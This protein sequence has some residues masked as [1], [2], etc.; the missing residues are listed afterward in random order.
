MGGD[1]ERQKH[2]LVFIRKMSSAG[3]HLYLLFVLVPATLQGY[4]SGNC[5]KRDSLPGPLTTLLL[6]NAGHIEMGSI[7]PALDREKD[8]SGLGIPHKSFPLGCFLT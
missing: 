5:G 8:A 1:A 7:C 3:L 6:P 2:L 4:Q